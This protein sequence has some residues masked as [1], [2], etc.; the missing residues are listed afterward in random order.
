MKLNPSK[1]A[2][3]VG[4]FAGIMHVVWGLMVVTNLATFWLDWVLGLH[5]LNNPFS[6]QPFD[7]VKW[8][9]LVVVTG[10]VGYVVGYVF[11]LVWNKVHK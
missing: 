2:L 10:V 5:F 8:V 4:V 11:S 9:T 6:V 7:A 1:V 3:V